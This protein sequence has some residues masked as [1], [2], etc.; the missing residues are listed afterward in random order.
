MRDNKYLEIL[1]Y[2]IWENH[3]CDVARPNLVTIKY[4]RFSKRQLGSIKLIK[5]VR[6]FNRYLKK[7]NYEKSAFEEETISLI[8]L[9]KYFSYDYIPE[10]V[11]RSTI[12]HELCHYTHGFNSPLKKIY[13]HPHRGGI[14]KKEL[15]RRD[16]LDIYLESK[17]WLSSNWISIIS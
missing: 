13:K 11:V 15:K 17:K 1:L 12:A 16:L 4:G 8:T 14:V 7:Y 3:F 9:T 10:H 2:D 6:T 5:D